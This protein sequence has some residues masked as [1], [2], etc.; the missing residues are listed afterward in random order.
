[1]N[2]S[3]PRSCAPQPPAGPISDSSHGSGALGRGCSSAASPSGMYS[4]N[5][6]VSCAVERQPGEVGELVVVRRRAS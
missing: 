1:M 4:M 6:T 2:A 3:A 5:R